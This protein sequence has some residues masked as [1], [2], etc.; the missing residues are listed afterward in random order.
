MRRCQL[1]LLFV[2]GFLAACTTPNPVAALSDARSDRAASDG[3]APGG[4]AVNPS[5][6]GGGEDR[7]SL[8]EGGR[9]DAG[10]DSKV[11]ADLKRD[12]FTCIP[13]ASLG[14]KTSSLLL[15]CNGA[16]SGT[17]LV[18]CSPYLCDAVNKRCTQCDPKGAPVCQGKD[19]LT[20]TAE[21]LLV[22]TTCPN[23]CVNGSCAGCALKSYYK[24]ADGDGF[25]NAVIKLDA[26]AQPWGFVLNNLDC[27]DLDPAA[28][29]G[30]TAFFNVP[31]KGAGSYD[32]NCD[33]VEEKELPS[34]VAC[35]VSGMTCV[36]DGW[37]G[38]VPGCGAVGV[39]AKCN[40]Q[41]GMP[42]GCGVTT[43]NK[44]QSCH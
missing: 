41:G 2:I 3:P 16:G 33:K 15:Q 9:K 1:T 29:P 12:A 42:P 36:G 10:L 32:Y 27:D 26:C 43:S 11:S 25:G 22:K 23:G 40:K 30:Q 24:D 28:H 21:G 13:N 35:V 4:D 37:A 14:C 5:S 38:T 17:V 39:W 8:S 18:D 6:E 19:L 7:A 20:C 44:I 34:L 31:T